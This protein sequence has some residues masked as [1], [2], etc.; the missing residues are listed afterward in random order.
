LFLAV[1]ALTGPGPC[2]CALPSLTE[3]K[4]RPGAATLCVHVC[5]ARSISGLFY[6]PSVSP[7]SA[8]CSAPQGFT[9]L[10]T[11]ATSLVDTVFL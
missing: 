10:Y 9:F 4:L 1:T 6:T 5:L 7:R 8:F 3:I 2:P 11:L